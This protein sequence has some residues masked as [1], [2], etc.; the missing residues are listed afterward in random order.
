NGIIPVF[1][2][3]GLHEGLKQLKERSVR[4][5][6]WLFPLTM[7]LML[8]SYLL[9][10]LLYAERFIVSAG[11]FN[12]YLL[13]II[14]RL[15]F[16]QTILLAY[17]KT[18]VLMLAS[19]FEL[20]VNVGLSLIFVQLF[21]LMGVA[22]ATLAAYLLERIILVVYVRVILGIKL[23]QYTMIRKHLLWSGILIISF[24]I[25]EIFLK[26]AILLLFS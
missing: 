22:Y 1:I 23:S 7:G 25:V 16:P 5:A 14:T 8:V 21:G 12:V 6:N 19:G 11:V 10:P 17:K 2:E 24:I 9:F 18:S 3:N 4:I 13:L 20:L 15:L 26:D